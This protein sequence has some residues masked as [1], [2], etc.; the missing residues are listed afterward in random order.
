MSKQ[1]YCVKTE[2]EA[3]QIVK[4]EMENLG[5][6]H[7]IDEI[8][9]E[10]FD[11]QTCL[12]KFVSNDFYDE[13]GYYVDIHYSICV[14]SANEHAFIEYDAVQDFIYGL[15]AQGLAGWITISELEK[16]LSIKD[17]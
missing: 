8:D 13:S 16:C 3:S 4:Q 17:I 7:K 6:L 14:I 9:F 2:K 12:V 10:K 11:N 15:D 5:K 1:R